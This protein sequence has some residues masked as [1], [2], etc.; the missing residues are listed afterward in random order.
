MMLLWTGWFEVVFHGYV[1]TCH[2][3]LASIVSS[4]GD[5]HAASVRLLG[6]FLAQIITQCPDA[7]GISLLSNTPVGKA[8]PERCRWLL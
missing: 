2:A 3:V 6:G 7:Q 5:G 1:P 4:A 8:E